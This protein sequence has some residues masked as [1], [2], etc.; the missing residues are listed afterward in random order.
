MISSGAFQSLLAAAAIASAM[1][2]L[3]AAPARAQALGCEQ[4]AGFIEERK[5]IVARINAL[6]KGGNRVEAKQACA[7]FGRLSNNGETTI[8]WMVSNK[9]WCQIPDQFIANFR[10]EHAKA[11]GFRTKACAVAAQ[12]AVAERRAKESGG[13]LG[14]DALTGTMKV[15]A[16]AL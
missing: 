1:T 10:D 6:N 11:G 5:S 8:K 4:F 16:G 12:Q 3:A 14:G 7:V 13:Q 2:G 9:D 15:P